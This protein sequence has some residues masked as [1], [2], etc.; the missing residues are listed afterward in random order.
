MFTYVFKMIP[1]GVNGPQFENDV[2]KFIIQQKNLTS[3]DVLEV[4]FGLQKS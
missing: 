4:V 1:H 3:V 2:S